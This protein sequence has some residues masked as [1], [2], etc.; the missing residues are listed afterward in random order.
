MERLGRS[1]MRASTRGFGRRLPPSQILEPFSLY[2]VEV[3]GR[4]VLERF[5]EELGDTLGTEERSWIASQQEAWLSVWEVIGTDPG[6]SLLLR[7][8]LTLEER[9]VQEVS[10][11]RSAVFRDAILARVVD[12][13]KTSLLAGVHTRALAPLDAAGVVDRARGYQ[14]RKGAVPPDRLRKDKACRYL[15][16]IWDEAVTRA[17]ERESQIPEL[18]NTDGDPLL[19]TVDHFELE[20]SVAPAVA[21]RLSGIEGAEADQGSEAEEKWVFFSPG[22]PKHPSWQ[23][24]II[25]GAT[26]AGT[27][28]RVDTNSVRRADALRERVQ[29]A[30]GD[31]IRH[32]AREH[33]DPMVAL[34][35]RMAS[36]ESE[37]GPGS[38]QSEEADGVLLEVK[39]THYQDWLDQGIP[40]LE[41]LTQRER[42]S[43]S[44]AVR[45]SRCCSRTWSTG[46][47]SFQRGNATTLASSD[48]RWTWSD[49]HRFRIVSPHLSQGSRPR[50]NGS[51]LRGCREALPSLSHSFSHPYSI[52]SRPGGGVLLPW[53]KDRG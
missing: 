33:S 43:V 51:L 26:L 27:R 45:S 28:L 13:G 9:T 38:I 47:P 6:A 10:A 19:L 37:K 31:L 21:Q 48:G 29:I 4:S 3:E 8:L 53:E 49:H 24:T 12:H 25:G 5:M 42:P 34:E 14:R 41:G 20:P 44:K 46:R 15:L 52:P 22:N 16:K 50:H 1:W 17:K 32:R 40:A 39:T 36:R 7:D 30:C 18:Q 11:S 23:N 35:E 2:H